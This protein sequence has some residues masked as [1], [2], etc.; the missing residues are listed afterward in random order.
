MD[1]H[2][3]LDLDPALDVTDYGACCY[4]SPFFGFEKIDQSKKDWKM[5]F[6]WKGKAKNR[7]SN[8]LEILHHA[9]QFN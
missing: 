6:R 5:T 7:E 1:A 4:F 9:D 8:G 3:K 2:L